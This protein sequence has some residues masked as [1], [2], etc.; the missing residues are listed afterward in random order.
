[1]RKEEGRGEGFL[2]PSVPHLVGFSLRGRDGPEAKGDLG[3]GL[4]TGPGGKQFDIGVQLL[5]FLNSATVN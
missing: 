2:Y 1:M 3:R 5:F 4:A